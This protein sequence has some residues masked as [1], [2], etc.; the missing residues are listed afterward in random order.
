VET[1]N[2][3]SVV[4]I[5]HPLQYYKWGKDCEAWSFVDFKDLSVKFERMPAG[6]DEVL[7]YHNRSQQFFYILKGRGI[8]EVDEV[9]LIMHEGEGLHIEP[10][11]QH[12]IMNKEEDQTL[13]FLVC[14][15][16]SI[17][18]DRHNLV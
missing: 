6:T 9:I 11:R 12:K 14:S 13:E 18:D 15:Q 8:F 16:P 7:H 2:T 5:F 17:T 1:K 4:S 3:P 10:G